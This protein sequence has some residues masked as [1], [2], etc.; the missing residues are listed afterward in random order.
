MISV[1]FTNAKAEE[2][3]YVRFPKSFPDNLFPGYKAGT[4]ARSKRN[5][6]GTGRHSSTSGTPMR[7]IVGIYNVY[8]RYIPRSG[9]YLVYSM[10]IQWILKF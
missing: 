6:Y 7:Y 4:V 8:T 2:E 1:A 10:Y 5:F 9:V 3:T